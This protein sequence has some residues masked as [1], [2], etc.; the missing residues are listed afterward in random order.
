MFSKMIGLFLYMAVGFFI[1]KK[2]WIDDAH[3]KGLSIFLMDVSLPAI[4]IASLQM[5]FTQEKFASS[6]WVLGIGLLSYGIMGLVAYLT[7]RIF[8]I[9]PPKRQIVIFMLLFANT[10]F[11]GYP[12]ISSLFGMEGL[13][14]AVL[15]NF[16]F[17]VFLWTVGISLLS[18]GKERFRLKQL[19]NPGMISLIIGFFLFVFGVK[20]PQLLYEPLK[21]LGDTTIPLAMCLVGALL[22]DTKIKAVFQEKLHFVV[23]FLRLIVIPLLFFLLLQVFAL[24]N[25]TMITAV[26]ITAMPI[27]ANTAIFSRRF[28]LDYTFASEGILLTTLLSLLTVPLWVFVMES[29][30]L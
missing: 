25:N 7:V 2:G 29:F 6:L 13:F 14:D 23:A 9:P 17:T 8:K 18:G 10:A 5:P 27:A 11:A 1:K 21:A 28:D 26:L 24:P 16:W 12:V 3:T 22:S 15:L 4:T 30:L 19:L 20:I